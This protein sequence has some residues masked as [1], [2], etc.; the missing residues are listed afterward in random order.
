VIPSLQNSY[1]LRNCSFKIEKSENGKL[2]GTNKNNGG[3]L[4]SEK[5]TLNKATSTDI[6]VVGMGKSGNNVNGN[7]YF[8]GMNEE[9]K[10]TIQQL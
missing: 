8:D 5:G 1:A 6:S 2:H 4:P 9:A 10:R 7:V 3:V